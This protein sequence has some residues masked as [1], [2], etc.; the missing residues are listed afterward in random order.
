MSNTLV[1]DTSLQAQ[2]QAADFSIL[3]FR[4]ILPT[5]TTVTGEAED[6]L[7]PFANTL[8]FRDSTKYSPLSTNGSVVI[9]FNQSS[10]QTIDYFAFACR[11]VK[12]GKDAKE[13]DL[14]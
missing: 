3:G 13:S 10:I 14:P 6:P 1:V 4:S 9:T 2:Q 11:I 7:F 8:D 12:Y 5:V